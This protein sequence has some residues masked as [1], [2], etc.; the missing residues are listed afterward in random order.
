MSA[1]IEEA[2]AESERAR[3]RL[4]STVG[5]I[6]QR[7]SPSAVANHA[8]TGIRDKGSEIADDAVEAVKSRPAVASAA[9]AAFVLFLARGRIAST[10]SRLLSREKGNGAES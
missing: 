9:V 7:L 6:Q 2:K 4:A 1:Q 3:R 8:W 10:A 5:A